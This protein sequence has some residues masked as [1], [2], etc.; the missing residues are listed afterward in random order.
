MEKYT[1]NAGDEVTVHERADG[2]V[3]YSAKRA[4][5]NEK[6]LLRMDECR[7]VLALLAEDMISFTTT[8]TRPWGTGLSFP[9]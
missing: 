6:R 1:N 3:Y 9:W 8:H 7:F 2:V 4:G 5:W